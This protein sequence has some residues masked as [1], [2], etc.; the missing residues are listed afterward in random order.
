MKLSTLVTLGQE[1]RSYE[2]KGNDARVLDSSRRCPARLSS[3]DGAADHRHVRLTRRHDHHRRPVLAE[4]ATAV[5]RRDQSQRHRLEAL[6][7]AARRAAQG[8]TERAPHHDR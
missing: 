1:E 2:D 7:A 4:S 8:R 3:G 5:Q 6:L